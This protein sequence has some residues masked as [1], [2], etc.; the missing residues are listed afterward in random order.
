MPTEPVAR[1]LWRSEHRIAAATRAARVGWRD[2]V[3]TARNAA[4]E[5]W[6]FLTK[7]PTAEGPRCYRLKGDQ[8]IVRINGRDHQRWQYKPTS[9]GRIWYAVVP[10]GDKAGTNLVLLE[11][12]F[13]GH[14]NETIKHFT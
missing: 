4:A 13:T 11:Q 12:V 9:A 7:T 6:D 10:A 14:P 5:A 3:A 1:P 2:L 8:A